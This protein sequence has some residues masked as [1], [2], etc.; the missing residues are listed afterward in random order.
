MP[1]EISKGGILMSSINGIAT[2]ALTAYGVRQA[3]TANN[4][5]NMNTENFKSSDTV[6]EERRG[7]GVTAS[8]RQGEDSVDISREAVDMLETKNGY[9]ANLKT[10]KVNNE[11]EKDLLDIFE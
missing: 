8:V 1:I 10:L 2:S 4:I 7:G 3:V 11:M 5:A 6:F 9:E